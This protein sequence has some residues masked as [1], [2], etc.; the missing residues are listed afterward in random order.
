VS[1]W[2]KTAVDYFDLPGEYMYD[3]GD[4]WAQHIHPEDRD[5]YIADITKVFSGEKSSHSMQYRALSK[6]GNYVICSCSGLL[7]K[8]K[9][10]NEPDLFVG[11][12]INHGIVD[13]IDANT[14]LFNVYGFLNSVRTLIQQRVQASILMLGFN[15]FGDVNEIYG[16]VFGN[17]L[18]RQFTSRLKELIG[19][20]GTAFRMDGSKFAVIVRFT[21]TERISKLYNEIQDV[22]KNKL[23]IDGVNIPLSI[24]GGALNITNVG[25]SEHTVQACVTYALERSKADRHSELVF[26]DDSIQGSDQNRIELMNI[27]RQSVIKDCSGFYLCYQP[28]V[29]ESDSRV[30][31]MEALLRWHHDVYGEVSPGAFIPWLE[32]DTCFFELGNWILEQAIIDGKK[33]MEIYP[34]FIINVNVSY[35][36]LERSAFRDA[37]L[38]IIAKHNFPPQN[39]CIELTERCRNLNVEFLRGELEFFRSNGIKIALD[40]FGTG[41]SSLSL[42]RKIPVDTLKIDQ[43]FISHIQSNPVDQTIVETVIQCANKLGISVCIEGIE[44]KQISD[45]VERYKVSTHQGYYYSR[46][47]RIEKFVELLE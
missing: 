29:R 44:N 45:F 22:V 23:F 8:G 14:G 34:D 1:R 30:I 46:P 9:D 24:S 33:I 35:S 21:E 47:V 15:R 38:D 7:V 41:A 18:L 28:L 31:G 4:I 12:I 20:E 39:L 32:N 36:Q 37:V 5:A 17:N 19:D 42:L 43:A 11:T 2:S 27:I 26:F 16:Y 3:A 6:D 25:A 40:D 10:E 13:N